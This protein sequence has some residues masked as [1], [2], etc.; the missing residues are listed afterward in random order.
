VLNWHSYLL[1]EL[2]VSCDEAQEKGGNFTYGYLLV[3]FAMWKCK[4]PMGRQL[5]LVDKYRLAKMFKQWHA[6]PD[7]ENMEFNNAAFEKWYNQLI[8]ATHRWCIP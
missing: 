5:A 3:A 2:V 1:E 4:P 8:D 6:R 7:Q